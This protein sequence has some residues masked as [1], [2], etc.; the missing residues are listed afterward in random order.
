MTLL[1]LDDR[2]NPFIMNS[3]VP[4]GVSRVLWVRNYDEFVTWI[5]QNGLPDAVSFDHDLAPEHYTPAYFWDDYEESRKYQEWKKPQYVEKTGE[6]CADWLIEYVENNDVT[7]PKLFVHS[8]NPVGAD[9]IIFT[10]K[11]E[12]IK[13]EKINVQT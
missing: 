5:Y 10:F 7:V 9:N 8:A 4:T 1:F 2:R 11:S 12:G 13:V 3:I 6:D